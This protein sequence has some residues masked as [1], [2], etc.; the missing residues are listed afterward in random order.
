MSVQT[1]RTSPGPVYIDDTFHRARIEHFLQL[2]E[3]YIRMCRYRMAQKTIL[4]VFELEP[5]NRV[6]KSMQKRVDYVLSTLSRN[7]LVSNATDT[8]VEVSWR[9]QKRDEIVLVV[10]QD[11][12]VLTTLSDG[13]RK[14]GFNMVSAGSYDE[15]LET[16]SMVSP[17]IVI[18][19]VNFANGPVGFDLYLWV[20]TSAKLLDIPFLFLATR[21]DRETLIAGKRL[22]VDDFIVKPLDEGV[23]VASILHCLAR[24]RKQRGKQ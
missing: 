8:T 18:S 7:G 21:V 3:E 2:S 1:V 6:A 12:R 5:E 22:G 13:L 16:L 23:V 11:E 17:G 24:N 19:E 15:A 10:D 20:R 9:K 14:Y 4:K